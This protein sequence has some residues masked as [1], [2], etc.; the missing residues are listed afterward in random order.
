MKRLLTLLSVGTI[1]VF[2]SCANDTRQERPNGADSTSYRPSSQGIVDSALPI[3]TLLHRFRSTLPDTPTT[4]LGGES[5]PE[6]LSRALLTALTANDTARLRALVVSR[7][8][9]AWLYY[10]HTH[11]IRPPYEMGPDLVWLQVAANSEKGLV[12]LVRRYGGRSLRFDGLSC[13]DS[14]LREGPNTIVQGCRVRFAAADSAAREL[15]LFGSL[16]NRDGRYKFVSYA[17][18]L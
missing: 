8:E 18:D 9:F 11:W 14:V 15:Q 1:A 5:S 2:S 16:L 17:N 6:R 7:T 13:A 4:L 12:R 10:P 3:D